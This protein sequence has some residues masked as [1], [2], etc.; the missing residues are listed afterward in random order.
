MNSRGLILPVAAAMLISVA[1]V[2][3][4]S[5]IPHVEEG[6]ADKRSLH[7]V[8]PTDEDY[9]QHLEPTNSGEVVKQYNEATD[10]ENDFVQF[11]DG[12]VMEKTGSVY[13]PGVSSSSSE[14]LSGDSARQ[15]D[16]DDLCI[17]VEAKPVDYAQLQNLMARHHRKGANVESGVFTPEDSVE[18]VRKD[19]QPNWGAIDW[20]PC[21][22]NH[23]TTNTVMIDR[24][25]ACRAQTRYVTI[26]RKKKVTGTLA[27]V[28]RHYIVTSPNS[29]EIWLKRTYERLSWTG[30]GLP[31]RVEFHD[32]EMG[33]DTACIRTDDCVY[34]YKTG[35]SQGTK[36]LEQVGIAHA[37]HYTSFKFPKDSVLNLDI[38]AENVTLFYTPLARPV[39][40]PV[41]SPPGWVYPSIV[42]CDNAFPAR[43][44]GCVVNLTPAIRFDKN[45]YPSFTKHVEAAIESGLPGGS[46]QRPLE[47]TTD[48]TRI[49]NNRKIACPKSIKRPKGYSCDEYPFAS[50]FEGALSGGP[51][52]TFDGCRIYPVKK[53]QSPTG[54]SR[55][56]IPV[57]ENS[58][59]GGSLGGSLQSKRVLNNDKYYIGF[60]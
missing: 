8:D 11:A 42:R 59:S 39:Y 52:R 40:P 49:R 32:Y 7:A 17:T 5:S 48:K 4:S 24:H 1:P 13:S 38:S 54:F 57:S 45:R 41:V 60:E 37:T 47:R 30:E 22:F 36:Y 29:T 31:R 23:I 21:S 44:A 20:G 3:H 58:G 6:I 55:C 35:V 53:V 14:V 19:K 15:C 27:Y 12:S 16:S 43:R 25:K 26:E 2:A 51:G 10:F 46:I 34:E 9:Q 28:L 33:W 18:D 50:T 56:M